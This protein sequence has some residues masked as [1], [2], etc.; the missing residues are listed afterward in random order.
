MPE[1]SNTCMIHKLAVIS[2]KKKKIRGKIVHFY[3][4]STTVKHRRFTLTVC[5]W[6][7]PELRRGLSVRRSQVSSCLCLIF[8]WSGLVP[9]SCPQRCPFAEEACKH[10]A[11]R[12][13][14]AE[15]CSGCVRQQHSYRLSSLS[16]ASQYMGK[17]Y[18]WSTS[19][20]FDCMFSQWEGFPASHHT[21]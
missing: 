13:R 17:K 10:L 1:I 19:G 3:T 9:P 5:S 21:V 8:A 20:A 11:R 18:N 12:R 7:D 14:G 16:H 15:A 6:Y 4:Q 2:Q